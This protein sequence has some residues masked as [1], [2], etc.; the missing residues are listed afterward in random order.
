LCDIAVKKRDNNIPWVLPE[1]EM[2][3]EL[4]V[5]LFGRH[6]LLKPAMEFLPVGAWRH[7]FEEVLSDYPIFLEMGEF[8]FK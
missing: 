5:Q 2:I 6:S 8:R 4:L 7:V 1:A 3:A